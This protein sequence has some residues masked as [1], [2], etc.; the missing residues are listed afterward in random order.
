MDPPQSLESLRQMLQRHHADAGAQQQQ[1]E[2]ESIRA[3]GLVVA[4]L[5]RVK[6]FPAAGRRW[7]RRPGPDQRFGQLWLWPLPPMHLH[8]AT[9]PPQARQPAGLPRRP[10]RRTVGIGLRQR[11]QRYEGPFSHVSV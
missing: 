7:R 4:T 8:G 3:A 5:R 11:E 6:P 9:A 1:E 10:S 2:E